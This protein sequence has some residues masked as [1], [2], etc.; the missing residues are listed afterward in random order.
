MM[1]LGMDNIA[2]HEQAHAARLCPQQSLIGLNW[3]NARH[4]SADKAA[5]LSHA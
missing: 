5:I 2:A 4:T 1:G 3:L